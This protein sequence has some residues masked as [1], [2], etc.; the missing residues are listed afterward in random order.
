MDKVVVIGSPGSGKSTFARKLRDKTNLPLYYLDMIWHKPN[1]TN[2]SREDFDMK[3]KKVMKGSQWIIDGNY[4]RTLEIRLK[5]CD[6]IFLLDLP[7]SDCLKGAKSRIGKQREDLPWIENELDEEFK[8]WI[9]DFPK[10]QL[11]QIYELLEKYQA[12]KNII[13]FK[14]REEIDHYFQTL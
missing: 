11:P 8:Q 3:L 10:N 2:V 5:K 12:E 7:L 14:S 1:Q 13:I 4:Q 9:I 6:T